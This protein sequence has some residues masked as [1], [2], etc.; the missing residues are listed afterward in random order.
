MSVEPV[1]IDTPSVIKLIDEILKCSEE[2]PTQD[3]HMEVD[4]EDSEEE[5][6]LAPSAGEKNV[7]YSRDMDVLLDGSPE[8]PSKKIKRVSTPRERSYYPDCE[9]ISS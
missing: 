9:P 1:D 2:Q 7:Q 6:L 8:P 5:S 4:G 3:T